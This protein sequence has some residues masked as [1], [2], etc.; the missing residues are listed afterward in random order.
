MKCD[1]EY[2]VRIRREMHQHP[3]VG[4]DLPYTLALVKRELD[5]LGIPYTDKYGKS[6][7][8]ATVNPD[9]KG[10]VIGVRADMDALPIKEETGLPFA[11]VNEGKMHACGHDFHTAMLL[12][13][14]KML[15]EVKD[16]LRCQVRLIFQAGEEVA[17]GGAKLMCDDGAADDIDELI[18][19]HVNGNFPTGVFAINKTCM[20][21]SSHGFILKLFGKTTHAAR[22]QYGVDAISMACQV[23]QSI[24]N[25]RAR[26]VNPLTP[27]VVAIGEIHGGFTNNVMCDEV[28]MHGTIRALDPD[29]DAFLFRRVEE[30][31]DAISREMGGRYTLET[32][33][34]YPALIN[35]HKIADRLSAA[36]E[37]V[38]GKEKMAEHPLS[39]GAE[40][41]AFFMQKKPGAR[42]GLGIHKEGTDM[43]P[44]HNSKFS[45]DEDA[46][47]VAPEIF[48]QYIMDNQDQ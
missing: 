37:K 15:V 6:S 8:V 1:K 14:A 18:A 46:I 2:V 28:M 48:F 3:E 35:D 29:L 11:S 41:F 40:D 10:K 33:K 17:P 31:A 23:Y 38:V 34:H 24:Q 13:L 9:Q 43:V 22:P 7:L 16:Q 21:A 32:T 5:A 39:M 36:A 44:G 30:I 42:F 4:F 26:E 19:C 45:P 27:C 25:M 12:G 20:N 47:T